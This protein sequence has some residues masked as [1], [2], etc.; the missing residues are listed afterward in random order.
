MIILCFTKGLA[1]AVDFTTNRQKQLQI[2]DGKCVV[3]S[4][5]N[6]TIGTVREKIAFQLEIVI[7]IKLS[8]LQNVHGFSPLIFAFGEGQQLV[9]VIFILL[10]AGFNFGGQTAGQVVAEGIEALENGDDA[11]LFVRSRQRNRYLIQVFLV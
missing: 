8:K 1:D 9:P 3:V 7:P 2:F 11:V 5:V 4:G 10:A 6:F